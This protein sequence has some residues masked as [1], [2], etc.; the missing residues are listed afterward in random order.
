[1]DFKE[2]SPDNIV[3]GVFPEINPEESFPDIVFNAGDSNNIYS[4]NI[5]ER[6]A[7]EDHDWTSWENIG[8]I[9]LERARYLLNI[10]DMLEEILLQK[11]K[12]KWN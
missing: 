9:Y 6:R 4:N 2:I 5:E 8:E 11:E 7:C 1:M 10:D 12:K 3:E